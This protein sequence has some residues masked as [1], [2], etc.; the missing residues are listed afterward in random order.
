[1]RIRKKAENGDVCRV[2]ENVALRRFSRSVVSFTHEHVPTRADSQSVVSSLRII[3]GYHNGNH[4]H[5]QTMRNIVLHSARS[6]CRYKTNSAKS[7]T[8]VSGLYGDV[9]ISFSTST[10]SS[11]WNVISILYFDLYS[12]LKRVRCCKRCKQYIKTTINYNK[13]I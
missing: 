10:K 3:K 1:M 12:K 2:V 6:S 11:N 7:L 13:A 9:K 8:I 5:G 4:S